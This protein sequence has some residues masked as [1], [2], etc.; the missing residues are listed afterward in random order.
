MEINKEVGWGERIGRIMAVLLGTSVGIGMI[1]SGIRIPNTALA[2]L[3]TCFSLLILTP[4]LR[5]RSFLGI[6]QKN[7]KGQMSPLAELAFM[8]YMTVFILSLGALSLL[9]LIGMS[10]KTSIIVAAVVAT[11]FLVAGILDY[12][13]KVRGIQRNSGSPLPFVLVIFVL[14]WLFGPSKSEQAPEQRQPTFD[15]IEIR[16]R[17]IQGQDSR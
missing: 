10:W 15:N 9:K 17:G 5:W 6:D 4:L 8:I 16:T 14:L 11:I 12:R 1:V 7:E 2:M 13:D 3:G